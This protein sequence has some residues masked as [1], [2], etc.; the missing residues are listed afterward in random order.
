MTVVDRRVQRPVGRLLP[1]DHLCVTFS[2]DA[3]RDAVVGAFVWHGLARGEKVLYLADGA[4]VPAV[5]ARLR[6]GGVAGPRGDRLPRLPVVREPEAREPE[7]REPD[8]SG[9]AP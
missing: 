4:A 5:R 7:L 6:R 3:E 9:G 1:G 8:G 2:C